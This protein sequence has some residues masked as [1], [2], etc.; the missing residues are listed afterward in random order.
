M[1]GEPL[2]AIPVEPVVQEAATVDSA[3]EQQSGSAEARRIVH[4]GETWVV[5]VIGRGTAGTGRFADP[6]VQLVRF[7][8]HH[9][10]DDAILEVL[11]GL[12]EL[13][14]VHE[15]EILEWFQRARPPMEPGSDSAGEPS[16]RVPLDEADGIVRADFE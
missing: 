16:E 3:G 13:D 14:R 7:T 11:T 15:D 1:A 9:S 4:G 8:R 10:P 5:E 12:R 6:G 2:P